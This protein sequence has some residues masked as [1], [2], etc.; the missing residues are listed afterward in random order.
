MGEYYRIRIATSASTLYYYDSYSDTELTGLLDVKS[1]SSDNLKEDTLF[2]NRVSCPIYGELSNN[3]MRDV[4][5][6]LTLYPIERYSDC[7]AKYPYVTYNGKE[8]VFA[9]EVSSFLKSLSKEEK[10]RYFAQM[11]KLMSFAEENYRIHNSIAGA[12][13]PEETE[14]D[15]EEYIMNFK[16]R[17]NKQFTNL[18]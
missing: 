3:V 9:R 1:D 12:K 17:S 14:I 18:K 6:G 2:Q 11:K 15:A 16:K 13:I 4:I 7:D 8:K 5:T 10:S